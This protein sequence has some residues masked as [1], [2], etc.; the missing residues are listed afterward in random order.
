MPALQD[1]IL[2]DRQSTPVNRT[3]KPA[4][5]NPK[6]GVVTLA[7][8]PDGTVQ[9]RYTLTLSHRKAGG[10]MKTRMVLYVPVVQTETINGISSSKVV[11]QSF[12]DG[13]YTFSLGS[14]EQERNDVV[15]F[16]AS[17]MLTTKPLIH[18]MLVKGEDVF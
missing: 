4:G 3:F 13:T 16:V 12:Y 11:R 17:S 5:R 15:G 9:N 14:S 8:S 2:T 18:D 1:L 10:K 7:Y 6:T